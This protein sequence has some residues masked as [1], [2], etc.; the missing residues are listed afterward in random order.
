MTSSTKNQET[1]MKTPEWMIKN[2][3]VQT[4]LTR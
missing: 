1:N 4:F 3:C 2:A